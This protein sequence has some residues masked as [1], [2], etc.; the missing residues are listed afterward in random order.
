[1][2]ALAGNTT[3]A[4]MFFGLSFLAF[5]GA[6]IVLDN[7]LIVAVPFA[8]LLFFAGWSQLSIAFA[9]LLISLP[10]SIEY[11]V[12]PTLGTDAPDELLM[13][14]VS[15]LFLCRVFYK[16]TLLKRNTWLHPLLILLYC[17]VFWA[18]ITMLLSS[19]PLLSLKFLIAK[20]WYFGAFIG[21]ALLLFSDRATMLRAFALLA[22]SMLLV[23][24]LAIARHAQYGFSFAETNDA[25]RPFFRNHVN[26]SAM[27]V[28]MVP[29]WW[30]GYRISLK[31]K[32]LIAGA[33]IITLAAIFLSY[34]RGAWAALVVGM[35]AWEL[36]RRKW[37]LKAYLLVVAFV[38][39]CTGW[40]IRNDNYLRYAHHYQTT[41]FHEDFRDHLVATYQLKDLSTAERFYRWVAGVRMLEERPVIGFGP[42]TFFHEYKPYALPAFRTWVSD[43]PEQ[44]TVHNYFLMIAVEQ[45]IP[46]LL[47]FL[48][49]AGSSLWY[50]QSLFNRARDTINRTIALAAGSVM[51]MILTV[52]FLSDLIETDKVGSL[53][54]LC[55]ATLIAT[56]NYT[57]ATASGAQ[58]GQ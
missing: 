45:G 42:S 23:T 18:L 26:Y 43:N 31:G 1:M 27:L 13:I 46:G 55:I 32:W 22:L 2:K 58:P 44:S 52:N 51:V 15:F 14:A 6:A 8:F 47:I 49:L 56:G 4:F 50:A 12:S 36:I 39:L 17:S 38:L 24:I 3:R 54:F 7:Y 29:L 9:A 40:L 34:A 53:F 30:A 10:F 16:P 19:H 5:F 25:L 28:C 21:A 35:I 33:L 57:K 20:G 41:I 11:Q 37:L 48:L